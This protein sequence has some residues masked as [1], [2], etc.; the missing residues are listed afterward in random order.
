MTDASNGQ[1]FNVGGSSPISHKDLVALMVEVAGRGRFRL[2]GWPPERKAIDIGDFY[3]DSTRIRETLDWVP[4]T[5]L[6]EGLHKTFA[7]YR[8]CLSQ[9]IPSSGQPTLQ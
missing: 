2:V 5:S 4:R 3:A 7:Y 1:V 6:R 8:T 9:Y